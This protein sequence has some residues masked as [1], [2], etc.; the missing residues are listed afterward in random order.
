MSANDCYQLGVQLFKTGD[1]EHASQWLIEAL[2]QINGTEPKIQIEIMEKL[3]LS[4]YNQG[5]YR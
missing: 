1:Y 5:R 4:Y 3:T 2:S